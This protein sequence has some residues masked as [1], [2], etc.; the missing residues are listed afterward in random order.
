MKTIL[1]LLLFAFS[2]TGFAQLVDPFGKVI[3]HEI[4]LNKQKD[5]TYAGAIEWT[6]GGVDSLQRYI[7]KG[8]DV[9]APVMVRIVSKAPDHNIDVSFHKKNWNKI[10]SKISTDGN[11]FVDKV[12]R[13]M[14]IAGIGV[15]SKVA[16]IP[17][18]I[19]VKVG[20]QFPSTKTLIRITDDKEEYRKY[21][22][23]TGY[24]GAIFGNEENP[25]SAYAQGS[26]NTVSS[27]GDNTLVYI[28]IGLLSI[29]IILLLVFLLKRRASKNVMLLLLGLCCSQ[30]MLSQNP[31]PINV[32]MADQPDVF[33]DYAS[34]NVASEVPVVYNDPGLIPAMDRDAYVSNDGGKTYA[35]VRLRPNQSSNELSPEEAAEVN[36]QMQET[37]D[38]FNRNFGEGSPGEPTEGNQRNLPTD[39]TTEELNMLRRQV[40]Q[41]QQQVDLLSQEDEAFEDDTDAGGGALLYCEDLAACRRCLDSKIA[42]FN[43]HVSYW[44]YMQKFYLNE[45][46][47]LND[48]IEYGNT[49]ASMPAYGVAWGPI[50]TTVIRPAMNN[51]KKVYN[52]KFDEYIESIEADLEAIDDCYEGP[53]G[54]FRS[55]DTFLIQ[56]SAIINSLKAA[57]INK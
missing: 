19:T 2:H 6:T 46:D 38:D 22:R 13:T 49:L 39:R 57:R 31:V 8:L 7:V 26:T 42:K 51:F 45:V 25:D 53:E 52:K 27:G 24:A 35:L 44:N 4:K 11:K 15:R 9:K 12:F 5:G 14:N 32:P 56:A 34:T 40:Q 47:D 28:V 10:E 1:T 37:T 29:I 54:R 36:R 20:L 41:L 48:K 18:L 55:N 33:V 43:T 17:Y 16:G 23:K 50:L 3:T 30:L 21:L